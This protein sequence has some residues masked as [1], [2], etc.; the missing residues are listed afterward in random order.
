MCFKQWNVTRDCS[1]NVR[2]EIDKVNL[3]DMLKYKWEVS[4]LIFIT[5][6]KY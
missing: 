2:K 4:H 1:R 3:D 6:A 5:E